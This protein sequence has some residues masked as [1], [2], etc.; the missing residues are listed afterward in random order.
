VKV[1]HCIYDHPDNPWVG[2]GGAMRAF[3][4][5]RRLA[6]RVDV[7]VASGRFPGASDGVRDGVRYEFLGAPSTYALSRATYAA[8]ANRLLRSASYDVAVFDFS[9]YTPVFVPRHRP[10]GIT[11]HHL[12]GSRLEARWGRA[13][14]GSLRRLE[15]SMIRRARRLAATS[16]A[17][18]NELASLA[19]P[20]TPIDVV[21]AGVDDALFA[22]PRSERDYI[23]CFGRLDVEHKGLDT[24]LRAFRRISERH[25]RLG[26]CIAG[27]GRDVELVRRL[28]QDEGVADRV[29]ITLAVS[30][31][32]R[33]ELL[34]GALLQIMP[35]RFEG[36]GIAAAETLAAGVPLVA[37]AVGAL[38][39]VT[40][41]AAILV[42]PDDPEAIA[43]A[44]SKILD[45]AD[46]RG[47]LSA[48]GRD[49][50]KA[51]DWSV[52]ADAH[53][54]FLSRLAAGAEETA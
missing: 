2:G 25:P 22:L 30:E 44:A 52:V 11:V 35:S 24:L 31:R 26:L 16:R 33:N 38:P 21:G 27:R 13:L 36:F 3:E 17:T 18:V 10:V 54:A 20:G 23:L 45:D 15:R 7:V 37:T 51:H 48:R 4:I 47:R 5:Y 40:G 34:S 53:A 1:L 43:A 9:V 19:A 42:P 28:A 49:V 29:E 32:E 50:A 6:G 8:A 39:E 41:G 14:G 12:T 46:E